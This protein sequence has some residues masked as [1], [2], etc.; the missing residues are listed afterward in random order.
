[1]AEDAEN[2]GHKSDTAE[3][4]SDPE[5]DWIPGPAKSPKPFQP[6]GDN[7]LG[8]KGLEHNVQFNNP[9]Q[10]TPGNSRT[11]KQCA[12]ASDNAKPFMTVSSKYDPL[13]SFSLRVPPTK[14]EDNVT[15]AGPDSPRFLHQN[16]FSLIQSN[17]QTHPF[18]KEFSWSWQDSEILHNL[19][20]IKD[21]P[22]KADVHKRMA[23]ADF[24]QLKIWEL[25]KFKKTGYDIS[26]YNR[27][28]FGPKTGIARL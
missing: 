6:S 16:I 18:I 7:I 5:S 1:M 17:E 3:P 23:S 20:V 24:K 8:I 10:R 26:K 4:H 27:G 13:H 15:A 9:P 25:K 11:A 2:R 14:P 22:T 21:G 12:K 19:D 28:D